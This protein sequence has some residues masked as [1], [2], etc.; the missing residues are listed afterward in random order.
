MKELLRLRVRKGTIS[1]RTGHTYLSLEDSSGTSVGEGKYIGT[2]DL[3]QLLPE[4]VN[5]KEVIIVVNENE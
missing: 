2:L 4:L 5:A 1:K 3:H